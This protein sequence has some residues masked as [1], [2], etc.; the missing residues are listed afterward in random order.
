MTRMIYITLQLG[1]LMTEQDLS[2][3]EWLARQA[4]RLGR[5]HP[6]AAIAPSGDVDY[7]YWMPALE[8]LWSS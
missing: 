2:A 4:R 1:A 6:S 8:A 7:V 5:Q 3:E